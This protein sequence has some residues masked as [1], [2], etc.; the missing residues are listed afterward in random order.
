[1]Y[2]IATEDFYDF[3]LCNLSFGVAFTQKI[4][5]CCNISFRKGRNGRRMTTRKK[6]Q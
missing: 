6:A 1:M 5:R 4:L 3:Y 2:G